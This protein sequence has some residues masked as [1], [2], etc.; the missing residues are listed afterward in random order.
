LLTIN[1]SSL[2]LFYLQSAMGTEKT[3][4]W[5]CRNFKILTRWQLSTTVV[6]CKTKVVMCIPR[7]LSDAAF[8]KL[9]FHQINEE[10]LRASCLAADRAN[11]NRSN[12]WGT[13]VSRTG[14]APYAPRRQ[15]CRPRWRL[16]RSGWAG[17][18][19]R[20]A[21]PSSPKRGEPALTCHLS[22][23]ACRLSTTFYA[24]DSAASIQSP[25]HLLLWEHCDSDLVEEIPICFLRRRW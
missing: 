23:R 9:H 24:M 10:P 6:G 4:G 25:V 11:H 17:G 22:S 20:A 19:H 15:G 1:G 7:P 2:N 21:S 16:T 12:T 5:A 14:V 3:A 18:S 13:R 8:E